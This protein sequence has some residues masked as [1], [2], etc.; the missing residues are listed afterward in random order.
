MAHADRRT[1]EKLSIVRTLPHVPDRKPRHRARG[2]DCGRALKPRRVLR[3]RRCTGRPRSRLALPATRH[4]VPA[5]RQAL[6]RACTHPHSK[7]G[8]HCAEAHI[9]RC[10]AHSWTRHPPQ[11]G[12][13]AGRAAQC[14]ATRRAFACRPPQGERTRAP[15]HSRRSGDECCVDFFRFL[16]AASGCGRA[17]ASKR[18]RGIRRDGAARSIDVECV[19]SGNASAH[20][21]A[22]RPRHHKRRNRLCRTRSAAQNS[23]DGRC[24]FAGNG[25]RRRN[26]HESDRA[27]RAYHAGRRD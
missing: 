16:T 9:P 20:T 19:A 24:E 26:G 22:K 25:R 6:H 8:E 11:A 15:Y 7:S 10:R 3:R 23:A 2:P 17:R 4:A 18:T 27:A 5:H 21:D 1:L 12:R 14:R 13:E